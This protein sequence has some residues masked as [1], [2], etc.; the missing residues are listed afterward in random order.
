M[1]EL[2]LFLKHNQLFPGKPVKISERSSKRKVLFGK[3]LIIESGAKNS[4]NRT[5]PPVQLFLQHYQLFSGEPVKISERSSK[6]K[7]IFGKSCR[8][9][10]GAGNSVKCTQQPVQLFLHLPSSPIQAIVLAG[11]DDWTQ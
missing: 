7:V 4:V 9:E 1:A 8:I 10:S 6:R 5:E 2:Q 11:P 3:S